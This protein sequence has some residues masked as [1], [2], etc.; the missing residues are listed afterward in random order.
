MTSFLRYDRSRAVALWLIGVAVLVLG[1]VVLGGSTRLTGSGLSIT[2]WKPVSG[3]LPPLGEADWRAEFARYQA[4]P[5]FRL[6]NPSMTLGAFKTIYWWEWSHRLLARVL[7]VVFLIPFAVFALRRDL[8]RRLWWQ[9]GAIVLLC[10]LEPIVG[11]WM[12]ASGLQARVYVAP[13]RLMIHLGIAFALLGALVW[14]ALDAWAGSARQTLPSPWGGRALWLV[15]LIYLQV[16]LGALVAGNQAGLVYNDWPFFAGRLFPG[17]YAGAGL[18]ATL[19]HTQAAVQFNHRLVAYLVVLV[20]AAICLGVQRSA[21]LPVGSKQLG[22]ALL[23]LVLAQAAL[24]IATLMLAVPLG[25]AVAHQ[26]LAAVTLS[27]AVAFAWRI[28]RT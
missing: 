12:V 27:L 25:L 26:L 5:Q 17:D 14:T 23:G 19:A 6:V 20:A 28:R 15:G 10:A 13:E 7:G 11:W 16:L 4:I 2:Q 3:V 9:F 22:L 24:G 8:P 18:W 21:Y 1:M